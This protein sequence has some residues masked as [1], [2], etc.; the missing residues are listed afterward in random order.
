VQVGVFA[1]AEAAAVAV[2]ERRTGTASWDGLGFGRDMG[3]D[4][5]LW[6]TAVSEGV[7]TDASER[8]G[9]G[10]LDSVRRIS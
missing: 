9:G 7:Q 1:I 8:G 6:V 3:F 2:E 10:D 4:L 5:S